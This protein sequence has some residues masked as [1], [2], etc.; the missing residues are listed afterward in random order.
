MGIEKKIIAQKIIEVELEDYLKSIFEK[1]EYSSL[2]IE[3]TPILT[4]I[5]V[6]VGRPAIAIAKLRKREDEIKE[7]LIKKYNILNPQIVIEEVKN[8]YLDARIVAYRIKRAIEKGINFK[9]A[10]LFYI[11]RCMENGA[12]G[13]EVRVAGKL[14]GKE[15]SAAYKFSKGY[16]LHTG[17][18]KEVYVDEAQA[19]AIIPVGIVGIKV[20]ILKELPQLISAK[21]Q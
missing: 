12:I 2:K 11:E 20:R 1:A 16:I 13:I 8:P 7:T 3:K 4:R 17:F 14:L 15:R 21:T 6:Y 5:I 19:Q 9:K 10:S 18:L